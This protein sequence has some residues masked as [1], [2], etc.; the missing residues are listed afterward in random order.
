MFIQY[1]LVSGK[2]YHYTFLRIN[3]G[4]CSFVV[5]TISGSCYGIIM[6]KFGNNLSMLPFHGEDLLKTGKGNSGVVIIG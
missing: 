3:I 4:C 2:C 5:T 6:V 1:V